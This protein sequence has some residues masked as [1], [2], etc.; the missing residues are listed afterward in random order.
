MALIFLCQ[1]TNSSHPKELL[2]SPFSLSFSLIH[3]HVH[4]LLFS[5]PI[6]HIHVY[7]LC[8]R[9]GGMGLNVIS[10]PVRKVTNHRCIEAHGNRGVGWDGQTEWP[11]QS[12]IAARNN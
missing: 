5:K 7:I 12:P 2:I 6:S 10:L 4:T 3:T 11:H 1:L 8:A 9:D